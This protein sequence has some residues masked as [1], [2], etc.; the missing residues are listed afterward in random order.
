MKEMARENAKEEK[1][2]RM[3]E[4]RNHSMLQGIVPGG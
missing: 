3:A 4:Q 2:R 1:P